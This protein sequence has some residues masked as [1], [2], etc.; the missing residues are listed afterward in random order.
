M[1]RTVSSIWIYT[2]IIYQSDINV[3]KVD[4]FISGI[5]LLV[6]Y[7]S[8]FLKKYL[9]VRGITITGGALLK[10]SKDDM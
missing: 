8:D 4:D 3:P 2:K 6:R 7:L 9:L 1:E 5:D 10:K